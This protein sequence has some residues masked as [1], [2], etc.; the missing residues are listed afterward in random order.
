MSAV[1]EQLLTKLFGSIDSYKKTMVERLRAWVEIPSVSCQASHRPDVFKMILQAQKEFDALGAKTWIEK[2]PKGMEMTPDGEEVEY[3]PIML[4]LYPAEPNPAHKTLLLYGHLDVQPAQMSD[5]WDYEP[6]KLTEV[7]DK[8]YGRGSTDD[9]APVL[10]WLVAL[11]KM[12]ELG[13]E[14]P[15]NL[16]FC[17]EGMEESGSV[18]LDELIFEQKPEFFSKGID[19]TCISDNYWLGTEKP[20]ITYGLR[21]IAYF[22]LTIECASKDLHSGVFGGCVHE[23]M[24]DL[25]QVMSSLVDS[26]GKILVDG[27][28]DLVDKVTPEEEALYKS[29]DFCPEAFRKQVGA[30]KLI[31]DSKEKLLQHRWRFPTLSLHG[32]EG[33][34]YEPGEKTVIPR[35]VIGKF[36]IRLVP[37]MDPEKL[38]GLVRT[39]IEKKMKEIGTPNKFWLEPRG[40]S[41]AWKGNPQGPL[42]QAGIR[43]TEKVYKVTPDMTREGGSIPVTLSFAN[44]TG[45][46]AMLLPMGA[47]D[48]GAHGQNEKI[49]CRNFFEGTKLLGGFLLE[50]GYGEKQ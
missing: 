39:H 20:C 41:K 32:I 43:A 23:A 36:S 2:N 31:H 34:F 17:F 4:G 19:A 26:R 30:E 49:D 9:K 29:I 10:G 33:A 18:G 44:A 16:R 50:F 6:F 35:R 5:G 21:G 14:L 45:K 7:G 40:G 38:I 48:D 12:K 3:P 24:T 22:G 8:L 13:I 37:D 46:P 15:L 42:F 47:A 28:Y 1:P 27:V 11:E 25:I